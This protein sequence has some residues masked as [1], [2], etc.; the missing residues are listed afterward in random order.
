MVQPCVAII[1]EQVAIVE[2]SMSIDTYK[3]YAD[4][5]AD[6]IRQWRK[7]WKQDTI[8]YK[9]EDRVFIYPQKDYIDH[10]ETMDEIIRVL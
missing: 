7:E 2:S 10:D 3:Q 4:A 6:R 1:E 8:L 5:F 9:V